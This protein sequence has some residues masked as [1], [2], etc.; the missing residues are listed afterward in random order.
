MRGNIGDALR[1]TV[2][3]DQSMTA[4]YDRFV[5]DIGF[6]NPMSAIP[7]GLN[8]KYL[9]HSR[10]VRPDEVIITSAQTSKI[11]LD[12]SVPNVL[13]ENGNTPIPRAGIFKYLL[14]D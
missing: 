6:I 10:K 11:S 14:T 8:P 2:Q 1:G 9:L 4:P 12:P 7:Q 13:N 3:K 5:L